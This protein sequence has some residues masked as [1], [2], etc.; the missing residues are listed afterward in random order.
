MERKGLKVVQ[1]R[2]D[3]LESR[4]NSITVESWNSEVYSYRQF[5]LH[6]YLLLGEYANRYFLLSQD[7][8]RQR[9]DWQIDHPQK[10]FPEP[11]I[12]WR[13]SIVEKTWN[14]LETGFHVASNQ[15][16]INDGEGFLSLIFFKYRS[17]SNFFAC[18]SNSTISIL[19]VLLFPLE[20]WRRTTRS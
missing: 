4:I 7:M 15:L 10:P 17:F 16:P 20:A 8:Y 6:S 2:I 3:I 18:F 14:V 9:E 12:E 13:E 5:C 11:G 19:R 1:H